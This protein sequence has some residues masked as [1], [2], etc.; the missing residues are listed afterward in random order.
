MMYLEDQYKR[1][2]FLTFL[3]F[4][5]SFKLHR[6]RRHQVITSFSVFAALPFW[7]AFDVECQIRTSGS[8]FFAKFVKANGYLDKEQNE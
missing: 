1:P 2:A 6:P 8:W 7:I 5:I 3:K 4:N